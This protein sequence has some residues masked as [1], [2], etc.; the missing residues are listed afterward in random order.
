V[1]GSADELIASR[2]S[3]AFFPHGLGHLL[4]IQVHDIGGWQQDELGTMLLPPQDH[5]FLRCTKALETNM[6]VT[7]EPG[8]YVIDSLLQKWRD[9]GFGHLLNN[10]AIDQ[11]RPLGGVR[12]EDN[13]VAAE[14]PISLFNDSKPSVS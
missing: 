10:T 8:L 1:Q 14:Q 13:V 9:N 4:G 3:S 12:V 2:I 7:I 5:P 6:V 11:L